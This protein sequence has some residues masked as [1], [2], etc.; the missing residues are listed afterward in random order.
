MS[1]IESNLQANEKVP[2][3]TTA[4][5]ILSARANAIG[6]GPTRYAGLITSPARR[7]ARHTSL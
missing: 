3:R 1:Y 7:R 5:W 2:D 4:H 6:D